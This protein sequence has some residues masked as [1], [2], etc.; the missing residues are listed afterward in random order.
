MRFSYTKNQN[1]TA[2]GICWLMSGALII[3]VA[4]AAVIS[5]A[6]L[7]HHVCNPHPQSHSHS[8]SNS[9]L[10]VDKYKSFRAL[11][12]TLTSLDMTMQDHDDDDDASK[13]EHSPPNENEE[14]HFLFKLEDSHGTCLDPKQYLTIETAGGLGSC[15]HDFLPSSRQQEEEGRQW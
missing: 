11:T 4:H 3:I 8:H 7:I 5:D 13:N 2:A 6:F 12:P 10:S 14:Q 1:P 9:H 15:G